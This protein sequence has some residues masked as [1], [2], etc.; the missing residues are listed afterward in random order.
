MPLNPACVVENLQRHFS[1]LDVVLT[2][3]FLGH[4]RSF[5]TICKL[6]EY[7][8]SDDMQKVSKMC[9]SYLEGNIELCKHCGAVIFCLKNS[10]TK[11]IKIRSMLLGNITGTVTMLTITR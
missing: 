11:E 6:Q 10:C 3:E 9:R 8:I 4:V 7:T 2:P 1:Q 5:L